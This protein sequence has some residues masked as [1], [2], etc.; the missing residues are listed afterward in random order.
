MFELDA[1][2]M[3][4]NRGDRQKEVEA[5]YLPYRCGKIEANLIAMRFFEHQ[6]I[7]NNTIFQPNPM[8]LL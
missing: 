2:F 4:E 3:P 5:I 6:T 7:S 8:R 1:W